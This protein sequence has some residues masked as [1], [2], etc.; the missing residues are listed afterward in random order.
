MT[1]SRTRLV[2]GNAFDDT[3]W[4]SK[5]YAAIVR[6]SPLCFASQRCAL[7]GNENDA[8]YYQSQLAL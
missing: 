8:V 5:T 3:L 6:D 7:R 1:V 2:D 4:W